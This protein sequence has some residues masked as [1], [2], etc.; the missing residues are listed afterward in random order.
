MCLGTI[1]LDPA[2]PG[3]MFGAGWPAELGRSEGLGPDTI[4]VRW[5][6]LTA[7]VRITCSSRTSA[8]SLWLTLAYIDVDSGLQ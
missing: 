7:G 8:Q 3:Q 1:I 2:Q 4:A 6:P 5:V